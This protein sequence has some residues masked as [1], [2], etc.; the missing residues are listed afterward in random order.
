M[1]VRHIG[2]SWS[3]DYQLV[4][5]ENLH[6]PLPSHGQVAGV[7][8]TGSPAHVQDQEPW[9]I[10]CQSGLHALAGTGTP[11]LGI[12]FGHQ[13]LGQAF[14]GG[15]APNPRGPEFGIVPIELSCDDELLGA[16]GTHYAAMA[17]FDSVRALPE[18][19]TLLA[20]S[21]R[22][23]LAAVRYAPR[24]WGVQFHPEMDEAIARHYVEYY[25][26]AWDDAAG[27]AARA[28]GEYAGQLLRRFA[29]LCS[30]RA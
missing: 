24:V 12:C 4:D 13:L 30:A 27:R 15:V 19:A 22:E 6:E 3:G 29:R 9:M 28:E 16:A 17:H 7:V 14:G 20:R 10:R 2:D 5:C 18:G 21:A 11:V 26:A 8:V 1:I 25:G 23:E